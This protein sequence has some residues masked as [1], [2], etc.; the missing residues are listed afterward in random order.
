VASSRR[1]L[2][3]RRGRRSGRGEAN[4][5][6]RRLVEARLLGTCAD[7]LVRIALAVVLVH[8]HRMRTCLDPLGLVAG[9]HHTRGVNRTE[10]RLE[11]TGP[12]LLGLDH[13]VAD[14]CKGC[15]TVG[16]L[17]DILRQS[18]LDCLAG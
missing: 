11:P 6:S 9:V 1:L 17:A 14:H 5:F 7:D 2:L 8:L 16:A 3:G 12:L 10:V 4:G 13:H 15:R 18:R